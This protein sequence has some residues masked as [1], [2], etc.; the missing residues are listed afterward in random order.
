[1]ASLESSILHIIQRKYDANHLVLVD[2]FASTFRVGTL[3]FKPVKLRQNFH[4]TRNPTDMKNLLQGVSTPIQLGHHMGRPHQ[5]SHE[6][7][8]FLAHHKT[9]NFRQ[10]LNLK[11]PIH[12]VVDHFVP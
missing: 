5:F 7:Y 1:M 9:Q 4:H 11:K 6:S 3:T 12:S 8:G 10:S 2:H